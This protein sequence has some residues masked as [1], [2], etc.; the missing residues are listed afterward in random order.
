MS[1]TRA[2]STLIAREGYSDYVAVGLGAAPGETA[3]TAPAPT[4]HWYDTL[5]SV[6]KGALSVYGQTQKG[7]A[8]KE[9]ALAQQAKGGGSSGEMPS[10]VLPVAIGGVGLVAVLMLSRRK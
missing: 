2:P 6:G 3:P 7:E 8:Y 1:Y 10:W 4:T 5:L 9:I